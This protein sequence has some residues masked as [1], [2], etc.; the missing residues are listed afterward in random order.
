MKKYIILFFLLLVILS[1]LFCYYLCN[2]LVLIDGKPALKVRLDI[3]EDG[4]KILV[5]VVATLRELG[6]EKISEEDGVVQLQKNDQIITIDLNDLTFSCPDVPFDCFRPMP[7]NNNFYCLRRGNEVMMDSENF[8]ATLT[9]IDSNHVVSQDDPRYRIL[10]LNYYEIDPDVEKAAFDYV[11]EEPEAERPD[12]ITDARLIVNGVDITEG[13]YV[14][15]NHGKETAELPILAI[16]RA[17]GYDAEMQHN[18]GSDIYESVIDNEVG[19]YTT[20][21]DGFGVYFLNHDGCVREIVNNDFIIDDI[22]AFPA[23]YRTWEAIITID[24]ETSTVYI[25]SCDPWT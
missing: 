9:W 1:G 22:C 25:D 10:K 24:Y 5:P 18:E 6:F 4:C 2:G 21:E 16:L 23:M 11:P 19:Y 15:I 8:G 14:R 7:G 3:S 13:N 17:L 12:I 20:K